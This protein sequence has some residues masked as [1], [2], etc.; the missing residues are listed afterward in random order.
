MGSFVPLLTEWS[1][2]YPGFFVYNYR[3]RH[4]GAATRA[5]IAFLRAGASD[6]IPG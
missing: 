1:P 3:N 4:I 5:T 6:D 2:P